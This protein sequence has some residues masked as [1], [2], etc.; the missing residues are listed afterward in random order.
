MLL[1]ALP[2]IHSSPRSGPARCGIGY[3]YIHTYIRTYIVHEELRGDD[4]VVEVAHQG[5]AVL[6][7]AQIHDHDVAARSHDE[8]EIA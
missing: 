8:D 5:H 2:P 4:V 6:S 3:A 1:S 7:F